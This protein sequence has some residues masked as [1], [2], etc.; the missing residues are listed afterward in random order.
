[1]HASIRKMIESA[2][3]EFD[4]GRDISSITVNKVMHDILCDDSP[5]YCASSETRFNFGGLDL[6]IDHNQESLWQ[7]TYESEIKKPNKS[8]PDMAF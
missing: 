1:M 3:Q 8:M 4:A 6:Y 2:L 7:F 5:C